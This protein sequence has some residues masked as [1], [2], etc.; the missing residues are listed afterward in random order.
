MSLGLSKVKNLIAV[1][2]GKGGV[3]KS[4]ITVQL[5]LSLKRQGYRV[6][7]CDLDLY[8]PS[9]GKMLKVDEIPT[10]YEGGMLPARALDMPLI[11]MA[12]FQQGLDCNF[13]RAPIANGIIKQFLHLVY[14]GE[15]DY[16]FFDLPPGTSDIH[17][18]LMQEIFLNGAILVTTPQEVSV[19]DVRKALQMFM[20]MNVPILGIIENMSWFYV[21]EKKVFPFG[22]SKVELLFNEFDIKHIGEIPLEAEI[23]EAADLGFN[24]INLSK[25]LIFLFDEMTTKIL[26][27]LKLIESIPAIH[28]VWNQDW[29]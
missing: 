9:L 10:S 13:I 18:T 14:W 29:K 25:N 24:G 2:A 26:D 23:S 20:K 11:S 7:I 27:R 21:E 4:T 3:G 28:L 15:L 19:L 16:L 17:M 1:G 8:G 5:A 22:K 12:Y 6:G